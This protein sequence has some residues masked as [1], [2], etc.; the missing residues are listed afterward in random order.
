M[1]I[2][3][4]VDKKS[5]EVLLS[6]GQILSKKNET[7]LPFIKD[8]KSHNFDALWVASLMYLIYDKYISSIDDENQN[9][10][11]EEVLE[12]FDFILENGME[13]IFKA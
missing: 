3:M 11:S 7:W 9:D 6:I 5:L 12:L 1:N 2:P 13:H 4:S 10:F 8:E